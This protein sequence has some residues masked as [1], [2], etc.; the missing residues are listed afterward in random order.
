MN[1]NAAFLSLAVVA[2][3]AVGFEERNQL[4]FDRRFPLL[5]FRKLGV[6]LG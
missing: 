3:G 5:L 2:L 4:L 1:R 6:T